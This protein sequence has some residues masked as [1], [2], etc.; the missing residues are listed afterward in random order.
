M[1]LSFLDV[2]LSQ[3]VQGVAATASEGVLVYHVFVSADALL[4]LGATDDVR[5]WLPAFHRNESLIA[6]RVKAM[7]RAAPDAPAVIE[8]LAAG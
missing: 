7:Q 4:E 3:V 6:A 8:S 5:T 1:K 2:H